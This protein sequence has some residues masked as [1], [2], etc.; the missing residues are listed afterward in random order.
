MHFKRN[1]NTLAHDIFLRNDVKFHSFVNSKSNWNIFKN[2]NQ[3]LVSLNEILQEKYQ[4]FSFE[5]GEHY[6]GIPTGEEY[7]DEDG[8]IISWDVV[9]KDNHPNRLKYKITNEDILISSIRL[10]KS[11]AFVCKEKDIDKIVFSNG[12][13]IFKVNKDWNNIYVSYLLRQSEIKKVLNYNIYRGLGISA[14]KSFDLLKIRVPYVD[15]KKQDNISSQ[16]L[17]IEKEIQIEKKNKNSLV[18][19]VDEIFLKNFNLDYKKLTKL[20]NINSFYANF[21]NYGSNQDL[22]FSFPFHHQSKVYALQFLTN[23]CKTKVKNFLDIPI[24]LGATISPG[25][26]DRNGDTYYISMESLKNFEINTDEKQLIS[27]QYSENNIKKSI[28]KNDLLMTRSG[29]A[30][31]KFALSKNNLS[32]IFS[33]FTMRIRLKNYNT[34]FAYYYFRSSFFSI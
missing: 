29:V 9:T 33:D 30:I 12:F 15:K 23:L 26:F 11:P 6:K 18:N 34:E 21:S 13:Y 24:E 1:F 28:K 5:H 25:D 17:S 16:I 2:N 10:A 8:Q 4:N 19:I 22:R 31:G 7:V 27:K 3:R 14:Y 20:K 32:G